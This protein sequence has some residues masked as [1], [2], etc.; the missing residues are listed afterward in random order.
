MDWKRYNY[1]NEN[2]KSQASKNN[3]V[4]SSVVR[5]SGEFQKRRYAPLAGLGSRF[6]VGDDCNILE[7]SYLEQHSTR[8][9]QC[10]NIVWVMDIEN[11]QE[12]LHDGS[13]PVGGW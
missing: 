1:R 10:S 4:V 13:Y 2:F 11:A 7:F 8:V 12:V 5:A 9:Y 6:F 3:I